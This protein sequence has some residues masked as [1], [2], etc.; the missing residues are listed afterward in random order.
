M[1]HLKRIALPL[2]MFFNV[3]PAFSQ[4]TIDINATIPSCNNDGSASISIL[5]GI[6]PY[7]INWY[8]NPSWTNEISTGPEING[9]SPG[10]YWVRAT[11]M[12]EQAVSLSL[13]IPSEIEI[14]YLSTPQNC[15]SING[16][17]TVI[18]QNGSLPFNYEWS[19]GAI[20]GAIADT[21]TILVGL[22]SGSYD[23]TVTDLNG[24]TASFSAIDSAMVV[25]HNSEIELE[26]TPSPSDCQNGTATALATAGDPPYTFSWSTN[27]MQNANI[28]TQLSPGPVTVVIID[29]DQCMVEGTVNVPQGENYVSGPGES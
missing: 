18:A 16:T 15:P 6:P 12:I 11:D 13:A 17:I 2:V 24:C 28:A 9:L 22:T 27:P 25:D 19:T 14:S 23:V 10:T 20:T 1:I 8:A 5:G 26:L 4:L 3:S 7:D 29:E 21:S